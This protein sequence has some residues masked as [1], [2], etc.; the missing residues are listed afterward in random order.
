MDLGV[1]EVENRKHR[2]HKIFQA[3]FIA[4]F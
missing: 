4:L 3:A 1:Q 2:R